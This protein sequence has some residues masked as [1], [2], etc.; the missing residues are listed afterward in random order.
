LAFAINFWSK[1]EALD[2]HDPIIKQHNMQTKH[3]QNQSDEF[4]S[5]IAKKNATA[6][7]SIGYSIGS[8]R[9]G[10]ARDHPIYKIKGNYFRKYDI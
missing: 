2:K 7:Y 10:I 1:F 6:F 8:F 4:S 3:L 5:S 9:L